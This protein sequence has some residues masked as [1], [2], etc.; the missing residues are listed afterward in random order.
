MIVKYSHCFI[1]D[2]LCADSYSFLN[3]DMLS[4]H[5]HNACWKKCSGLSYKGFSEHTFSTYQWIKLV[6]EMYSIREVTQIFEENGHAR[7]SWANTRAYEFVFAGEKAIYK[8]G[9]FDRVVRTGEK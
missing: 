1:C 7:S 5:V 2:K 8:N 6:G 9:K 4:L 3:I